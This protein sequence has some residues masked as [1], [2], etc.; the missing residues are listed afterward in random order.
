MLFCMK[1][2]T[3]N[4]PAAC[5]LTWPAIVALALACGCTAGKEPEPS[6]GAATNTHP[7]S[8]GA[9]MIDDITGKTAVDAGLRAKETIRKAGAVRSRDLNE[10]LG[11]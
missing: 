3:E 8:A 9:R 1:E 6:P 11:E 2:L 7:Q 4:R 5:L 10:A